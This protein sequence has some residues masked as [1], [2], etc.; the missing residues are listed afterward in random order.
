MLIYL[1]IFRYNEAVVFPNKKNN[2]KMEMWLATENMKT[3]VFSL[4]NCFRV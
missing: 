4:N 2:N 3:I 1:G